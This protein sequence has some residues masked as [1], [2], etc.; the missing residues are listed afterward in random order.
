MTFVDDNISIYYLVK[1]KLIT[2]YEEKIIIIGIKLKIHYS[3]Y[4]I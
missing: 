3:I 4:T 2:N 1:V